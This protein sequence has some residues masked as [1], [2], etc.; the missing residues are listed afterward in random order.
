MRA[1]I[2]D[3]LLEGTR[4][5]FRRVDTARRDAEPSAERDEIDVWIPQ[6]ELRLGSGTRLWTPMRSNSVFRIA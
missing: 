6:V 2:S 3:G 1:G 5:L 4:E